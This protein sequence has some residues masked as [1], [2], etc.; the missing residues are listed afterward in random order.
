MSRGREKVRNL[1]RNPPPLPEPSQEELEA[2]ELDAD[3]EMFGEDAPYLRAAGLAD[4][5]GNK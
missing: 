3:E 5:I 1:K 4:K 2:L